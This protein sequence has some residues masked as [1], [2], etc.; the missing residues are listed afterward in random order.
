MKETVMITIVDA[1]N[2]DDVEAA[3]VLTGDGTDI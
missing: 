2:T 3:D 1:V